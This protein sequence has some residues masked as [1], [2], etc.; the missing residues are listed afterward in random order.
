MAAGW[1]VIRWAKQ[2]PPVRR[3][4]GKPD[5]TA[6]HVLLVLATY[7]DKEGRARPS[8][9]TVASECYIT[10][11]TAEKALQRLECAGLI[12]KAGSWN[13]TEIWSLNLSVTRDPEADREREERRERAREKTAERVRRYRDRQ[14]AVTVPDTVTRNGAVDRDVTVPDTVTAGGSNGLAHRDV[15]VPETV[16][17]GAG[18]R[19]VTVPTSLHPQVRG[20]VTAIELPL[21]CHKEHPQTPS[22]S[23]RSEQATTPKRSRNDAYTPDFETFWAAYG[24]KGGKRAAAAEWHKALQRAHIETIMEKVGPYVESTPDIK[25]RKDAERW[26][27]NDGWESA[28]VPRHSTANGMHP[29]DAG[30]AALLGGRSHLRAL[31]GGSA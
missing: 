26:L 16:S 23:P 2:V 7:A 12:A 11:E 29:T 3:A 10:D 18:H 24:R 22:A 4:D 28:I 31:P 27:K 1:R 17:N 25:Y 15:T 8:V 13:G 5:T 19:D 6:H 20:G 9:S 21:N 14:R 30:I